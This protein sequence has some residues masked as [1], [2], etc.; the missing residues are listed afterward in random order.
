MSQKGTDANDESTGNVISNRFNSLSDNDKIYY[1]R[2][3]IAFMTASINTFLGLT[4]LPGVILAVFMLIVSHFI[5]MFLLDID[6]EEMGGHFKMVSIGL[7]SYLLIGLVVWVILYNMF[8]IPSL[9][10]A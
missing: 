3:V 10:V 5:A 7:F 4:E 8:V 9:L 1:M 6:P 2:I